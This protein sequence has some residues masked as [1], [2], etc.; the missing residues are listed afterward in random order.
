MPVFKTGAINRS[1]TSPADT[2]LL[3]LK[4]PARYVPESVG[5]V[6]PWDNHPR[7]FEMLQIK[8]T[9]HHMSMSILFTEFLQRIAVGAGLVLGL[10]MMSAVLLPKRSQLA[11]SRRRFR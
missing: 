9:M 4:G 3:Q 2:V 10:V 5:V 7:N 8:R 6:I 11:A 1:A